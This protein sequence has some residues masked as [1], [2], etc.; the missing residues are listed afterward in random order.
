MCYSKVHNCCQIMGKCVCIHSWR[1]SIQHNFH[2]L[3][4]GDYI[5]S[6]FIYSLYIQSFYI[7]SLYIYSL[8]ISSLYICS[9]FV[10]SLYIY[11]LFIYSLFIY[12]FYIYRLTLTIAFYL[13]HLYHSL[14]NRIIAYAIVLQYDKQYNTLSLLSSRET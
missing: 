10:Y 6:L 8:T 14:W 9:L 3:R 2:I 12:S 7:Y 5:Y 4:H 11:S 1:L 13:E